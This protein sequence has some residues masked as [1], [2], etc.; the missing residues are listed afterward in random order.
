[1]LYEEDILTEEAIRNW[2]SE[3]EQDVEAAGNPFI[4]AVCI[5]NSSTTLQ[6]PL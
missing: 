2:A 4:T 5:I 3:Q 6:T 1:M